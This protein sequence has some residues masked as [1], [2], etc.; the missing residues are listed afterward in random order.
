MLFTTSLQEKRPSVE[1][2]VQD[3]YSLRSGKILF[4]RASSRTLESA[5]ARVQETQVKNIF[6]YCREKQKVTQLKL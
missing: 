2:K 6:K 3:L 5:Q 1:G 4:E